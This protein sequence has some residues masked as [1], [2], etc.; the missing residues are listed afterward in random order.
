MEALL[1][2]VRGSLFVL[3]VSFFHILSSSFFQ[4]TFLASG[5]YLND[6]YLTTWRF[7]W[8]WPL[9]REAKFVEVMHALQDADR[10]A[11]VLF[12]SHEPRLAIPTSP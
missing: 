7:L 12:D 4:R 2:L 3:F 5:F 11:L 1:H 8:P 6:L 9:P 10:L